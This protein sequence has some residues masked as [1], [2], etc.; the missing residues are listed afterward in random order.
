MPKA[1]FFIIFLLAL[2]SAALAQSVSLQYD[3][4]VP[5][6][7]YAAGLLEKAL[8][9]TGHKVHEGTTDLV[10]NLAMDTAKLGDEAYSIQPQGKQITIRGGDERGLIY[11]SFSLVEDLR[12]G[13]P[14]QKVKAQSAGPHLS[15]RAIKFNL[16][17]DSYR[18]SEALEQHT[19]TCRD[20][21]FWEAFLDMMAEN[22]FN[23]LTLWNLHPFNFMI[24]AKNFPEATPF[25]D[26]EM[27]EW[28][29]LYTAIFRMARQRGIDTYIVN[30]NIFV[31]PEF[32]KANNVAMDN[33]EHHIHAQGDTSDIVKRYTRESVT[34]VLEEYPDLSGIGFTHGEGMGGMTPQQRQDWFKETI[35]E[36]MRLA[37]R[38]SKLIHR[39]PLSA[40][41]GTGGST[42]VDTEQLTREAMEKL[43]FYEEP[44][45]VE[46]KFN[47]SHAHSTPELVK[48]HGGKLSDT[49]FQ[50]EPKN[51]KIAWMARNEDFF[52]LRWGEPDFIRKHIATNTESYIGGYFVGSECYIPA[53]DYFTKTQDS[54]NWQYAFQRQWLFYMLWGR[55]LYNPATPDEVFKAAFTQR[56]G[57]NADGLLEAYALASKTPLR[58]ASS[59]DFTWDFTLYSEGVSAL[60]DGRVEYIS[61]DL[62]INQPPVDPDYVS[63][64]DYVKADASGIFSDSKVTPPMLANL[65]EQDCREALSLV[66]NI[67]TDTNASLRYEVADVKAWA[68]LGLYFSEKLQGAVALQTYRL[69][70]G[71]ENKQNAVKH[72]ENAL[73][74]WDEVVAITQPI[75]QEM[76]LTHYSEED[77]S[78]RF[79]WA[80]LRP[81]VARDIAIA[82][83]ATIN[84]RE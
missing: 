42:S 43:D 8:S 16:P 18:H 36:G 63:I 80:L 81:E 39:V 59:F 14:P 13:I 48:V 53:K 1:T 32:A 72:L 75:Y 31:S 12:N 60:Q 6:A 9:E 40:N 24:K 28:H 27:D 44:I 67:K 69:K 47:W 65:L 58:L 3:Q 11:G 76:P 5:Q 4:A 2:A 46:I 17:W 79:H 77:D 50:P 22:R 15:F 25:T 70:G 33:L 52:C 38:K 34:Q 62:Q 10:I 26:Q 78:R 29:A 20:V 30:W 84:A 83:N 37:N 54:V 57:K 56:Y 55:L 66:K 41:L 68:N 61:V 35:I 73:G 21:R 71:K 74:F 19:E 51:Y 49:Y 45:W 82:K 64:I 23:A 7:A